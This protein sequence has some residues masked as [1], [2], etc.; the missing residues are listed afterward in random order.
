MNLLLDRL[1]L[2]FSSSVALL[3]GCCLQGAGSSQSKER[4]GE[5]RRSGTSSSEGTVGSSGVS[6][7]GRGL[8]FCN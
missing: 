4:K 3:I 7:K 8:D 6:E 2:W 5:V 1:C